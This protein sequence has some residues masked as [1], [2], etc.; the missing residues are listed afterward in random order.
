MGQSASFRGSRLDSTAHERVN[1]RGAS[2]L[3]L[4]TRANTSGCAAS[5]SSEAVCSLGAGTLTGSSTLGLGDEALSVG[6]EVMG[7]FLTTSNM[8]RSSRSPLSS[9]G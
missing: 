2:G 3:H 5:F 9:R 7:S 8:L 6:A 1:L 4:S